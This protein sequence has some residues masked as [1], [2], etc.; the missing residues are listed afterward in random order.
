VLEAVTPAEGAVELAHDGS[1]ILTVQASDENLRELEIDHSMEATLDE[2]SVY[3]DAGNPY[4]TAEDKT[5]FQEAGV[6]VD[7]D[8]DT[9]T[10]T[11]DF[12]TAISDAFV[13]NGGITFYLVAK[14][15]AGNQKQEINQ[16]PCMK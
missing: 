10:W 3:A 9:Q 12:G 14:D 16:A 8:A 1:F 15:E 5:K 4:G 13:A 2:F 6:V 7:Y 11:I